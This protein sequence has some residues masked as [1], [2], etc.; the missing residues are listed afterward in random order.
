LAEVYSIISGKGGVGKTFF[1]INLATSLSELKK[2]V[3]LVDAN[4]TSPNISIILKIRN[5]EKTLHDFL[6]FKANIDEIIVKTPF[7]FDLIPGSIK[8]E[9]LIDINLDRLDLISKL[10]KNYD[11]IILDSSAG[12]GRETYSTIKISDETIVITNPEKPS[13]MDAIRAIKTSEILGI[14]VKGVVIN[15]YKEDINLSKV[16]IILGK[17]IL[18]TIR[19]DENVRESFNLGIPLISYLP[20][21]PASVDILN[22]ARKIAKVEEVEEEKRPGILERILKVLGWR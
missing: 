13:L 14:P 18:G 16:E 17:S 6:K 1:S 22:I 8:I 5:F 11:Y 9:D 20:E 19:E 12:L 4:I 7:G 3:L 21:S 10:R 15:R 2:K